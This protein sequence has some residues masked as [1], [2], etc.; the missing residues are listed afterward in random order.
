MRLYFDTN[1]LLFLVTDN[2][3]ITRKFRPKVRNYRKL[4]IDFMYNER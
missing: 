2:G 4:E 1:I 3:N